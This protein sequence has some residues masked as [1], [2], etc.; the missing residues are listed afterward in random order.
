M[1]FHLSASTNGC[2]ARHSPSGTRGMIFNGPSNF[3]MTMPTA[4]ASRPSPLRH[5]YTE[6]RDIGLMIQFRLVFN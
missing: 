5:R 1:D 3:N 6:L 4:K 2:R